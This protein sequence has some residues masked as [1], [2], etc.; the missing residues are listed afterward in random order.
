MDSPTRRPG[1]RRVS[2]ALT[3]MKAACGPPLPIGTPYRWIEPTTISAPSEPGDGISVSASGSAATTTSAPAAFADFTSAEMS[4]ISPNVSG[5]C[6]MTAAV[7]LLASPPCAT[8]MPSASA[9]VF[10]TSSDCGCK[11]LA[12]MILWRCSR[13]WRRAMPAASATAVASSSSEAL[14]TGRP[15]SSVTRVWKWKSISSRP[16]LISG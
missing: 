14:A 16:W 4:G 12:T 6:T 10:S 3:A 13:W 9:R 15:A 7:S 5:T 8:L 11:V 1:M 2:A